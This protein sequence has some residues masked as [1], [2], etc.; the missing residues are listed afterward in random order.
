M[1]PLPAV[2][3]KRLDKKTQQ[4]IQSKFLDDRIAPLLVSNET[5]LRFPPTHILVCEYD[6]LRDDGVWAVCFAYVV[7]LEKSA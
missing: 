3:K 1:E 2:A 5:L 7:V 6:P 4:Y